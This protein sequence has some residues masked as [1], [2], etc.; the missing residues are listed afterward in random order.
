MNVGASTKYLLA[1]SLVFAGFPSAVAQNLNSDT[2]SHSNYAAISASFP[3]LNITPDARAAAMGEAGVARSPDLNNL[4]INPSAMVFLPSKSGFG[5]SYNPWLQPVTKDMSL[6]YVSAYLNSGQQA[7]GVSM[8]YFSVGE[9]TFRDEHAV[10]LGIV[11]PVEYA[12]DL[13]YARKLTPDFSLGATARYVQSR[14]GLNEQ[15][16]SLQTAGAAVAADVSAYLVKPGRLFGYDAVLAGGLNLSNIGPGSSKDQ[17]GQ[18]HSLPTNLKLG[19]SAALAIDNISRLTLAAD[20]NKSLVSRLRSAGGDMNSMEQHGYMD[21]L[22]GT[23]LSLGLE[24]TFKQSVSFRTG[25]VYADPS[26]GNRSY[27]SLGAGIKYQQINFDIAY[28]PVNLEKTP[29]ANTL[30]IGLM[31]NFGQIESNHNG[32]TWPWLKRKV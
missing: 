21:Q 20:L 28:L 8:R 30:K 25:Y 22:R 27:L 9:S 2:Q 29:M 14:L 15:G 1:L 10:L 7:L 17:F 6:S 13:S 23:A 11:H 26:K 12:F 24:Y 19:A 3:F 5:I 32:P 18:L 4:S 16:T 31:F